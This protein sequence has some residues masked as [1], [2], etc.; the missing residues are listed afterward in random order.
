MTQGDVFVY[1]AAFPYSVKGVTTPNRDGTYSIYINSALPA[2]QQKAALRHELCHVRGE[3]FYDGGGVEENEQAADSDR[4]AV[5]G[6]ALVFARSRTPVSRRGRRA[7]LT[8]LESTA[9]VVFARLDER[10]GANGK[11]V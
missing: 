6:D 7:L 8:V 2:S 3:H 4:T 10:G 1:Y 9:D 11:S 5:P